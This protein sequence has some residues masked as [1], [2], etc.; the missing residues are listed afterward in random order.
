MADPV[1]IKEVKNRANRLN[2]EINDVLLKMKR[3]LSGPVENISEDI[4][5]V[6]KIM[7][8]EPEDIKKYGF[9]DSISE[10]EM[11]LIGEEEQNIDDAIMHVAAA[12]G[13]DPEDIKKFGHNDSFSESE[14]DLIGEEGQDID[15]AIMHVAEAM[16]V[17]PEDIKK[18]GHK[19]P[20]S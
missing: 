9:T 4:L 10:S 11:D 6:A 16:G 12:M 19:E 3:S 14:M 13:V 18:Y 17:D 20:S 8:V 1:K 15:D 2:R 5:Q 7:G